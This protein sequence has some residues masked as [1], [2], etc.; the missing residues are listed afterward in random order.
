MIYNLYICKYV[1]NCM[2]A[3]TCTLYI[4]KHRDMHTSYIILLFCLQFICYTLNH[5]THPYI[6]Y[7]I[8][9]LLDYSLRKIFSE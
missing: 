3:H 4:N 7:I 9:Q 8:I 1:Y 2:C 5:D 6:I